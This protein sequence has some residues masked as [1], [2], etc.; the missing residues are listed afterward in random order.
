MNSCMNLSVELRTCP[1]PYDEL[2]CWRVEFNLSQRKSFCMWRGLSWVIHKLESNFIK[3]YWPDCVQDI[4]LW[5]IY[6][7]EGPDWGLIRPNLS[8]SVPH[9]HL[10]GR[11]SSSRT[12]SDPQ[13]PPGPPPGP[14]RRCRS[15]RST[16]G[17][18]RELP[19]AR[20]EGE[21]RGQRSVPGQTGGQSAAD[22]LGTG[23]G[24][25][26]SSPGYVNCMNTFLSGQSPPDCLS[27]QVPCW[28]PAPWSVW[29]PCLP[30]LICPRNF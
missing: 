28:Q 29:K 30:R 22:D 25:E 26:W 9:Q 20:A 4:G 16:W 14:A 19:T 6:K 12:W 2:A 10:S 5:K 27:W 15:W 8:G 7:A 11:S 21:V 17:S 3:V 24:S 13:P 18:R 23:S 1:T